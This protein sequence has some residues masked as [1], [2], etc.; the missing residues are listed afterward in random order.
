[1]SRRVRMK[2]KRDTSFLRWAANY[3]DAFL[4]GRPGEKRKKRKTAQK[5]ETAIWEI[6]AI[7]KEGLEGK[8]WENSGVS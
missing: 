2:K 6:R 5:R 1:L 8:P 3:N 7:M 4:H